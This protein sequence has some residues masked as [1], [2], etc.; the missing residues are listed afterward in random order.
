MKSVLCYVQRVYGTADLNQSL[1][2]TPKEASSLPRLL[3][4]GSMSRGWGATRMHRG[5]RLFLEGL[6]ISASGGYW[7]LVC[8]NHHGGLER[9]KQSLARTV[10]IMSSD[11]L[12]VRNS[13]WSEFWFSECHFQSVMRTAES[14]L[15]ANADRI[16][17]DAFSPKYFHLCSYFLFA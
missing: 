11:G 7:E 3:S 1:P 5:G 9:G 14:Q 13:P 15:R 12:L 6:G 4:Y 16:C 8:K 17:A 2:L 10:T